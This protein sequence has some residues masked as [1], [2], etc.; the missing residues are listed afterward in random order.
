METSFSDAQISS[1]R[2]KEI[3][4]LE[5][6][7]ASDSVKE[8]IEMPILELE[9]MDD[10]KNRL[11]KINMLSFNQNAST[12]EKP[13]GLQGNNFYKNRYTDIIPSDK[14]RVIFKNS[15]FCDYINASWYGKEAILTQ[16]PLYHTV[17]EFW[18]MVFENNGI[19]VCVTD[20]SDKNK[21]KTANYWDK[22]PLFVPSPNGSCGNSVDDAYEE[23]PTE[24][25]VDTEYTVDGITISL[26]VK[27]IG[28]PETIAAH[29]DKKIICSNF[30]V[31]LGDEKKTI[32]RLYLENW[33]DHGICSP[34]LLVKLIAL[35][36]NNFIPVIHCSAGIGRSGVVAI[37]MHFINAYN[38]NMTIPTENEID[39]EIV[40][41]RE[42]RPGIVQ[43]YGQRQLIT[44]TL[45]EYYSS[46]GNKSKP[47]L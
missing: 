44:A 7:D 16:G 36:P 32:S 46:S 41:L 27:P 2:Y 30:E 4:D 5:L 23:V 24:Y 45:L 42:A 29:G 43:T 26:K 37:I 9:S 17:S 25:A 38:S 12:S 3:Y 39:T 33:P 28:D 15:S 20:E 31:S 10:Y 18:L 21:I 19:I 6:S 13:I 22:V 40:N 8:L 35:F 34:K 11:A 14:S 47:A 1:T